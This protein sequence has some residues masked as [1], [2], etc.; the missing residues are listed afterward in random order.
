MRL[1]SLNTP[2]HFQ[3][4]FFPFKTLLLI[5]RAE[6][7]TG[8]TDSKWGHT[9]F[10]CEWLCGF[11]E[12]W[13]LTL[14]FTF[15][16]QLEESSYLVSISA[17][18][19]AAAELPFLCQ[20]EAHSH[21]RWYAMVTQGCSHR[22]CMRAYIKTPTSRILLTQG[23]EFNAS[24]KL[25]LWR[26]CYWRTKKVSR[27]ARRHIFEPSASAHQRKVS[28]GPKELFL[29]LR[30]SSSHEYSLPLLGG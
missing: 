3:A 13:W 30:T 9:P 19:D 7:T 10:Q 29:G 8:S 17:A 1:F 24:A 5:V 22:K 6:W 27:D 25:R 4:T 23:R 11:Q 14:R 12:L 16:S 20:W 28:L 15:V 21:D 2:I 18:S 26:I